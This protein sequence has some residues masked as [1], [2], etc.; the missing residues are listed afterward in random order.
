MD[1]ND[2]G[3]GSALEL[4]GA[5]FN[6][7]T[8]DD[9]LKAL[10]GNRIYD[11]VPAPNKREFPYVSFGPHR[12][13]DDS[14]ADAQCG[15]DGAEH[16]IVIDCWS[17]ALGMPEV[18]RIAAAVVR[19]LNNLDLGLYNHRLI[20]LAHRDTFTTLDPDGMTNH[21]V[22]TFEATTEPK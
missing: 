12:E 5:I 18:K 20:S 8:S 13:G 19:I 14:I 17:R 11:A 7:L 1:F 21:A 9:G 15:Y 22:S 6:A 10:V 3:N 4:Q 16:D 2:P